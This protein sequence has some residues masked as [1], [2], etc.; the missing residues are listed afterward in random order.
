MDREGRPVAN[1]SDGGAGRAHEREGDAQL[2]VGV[3]RNE[4]SALR[5]FIARFEPILLDQARR[6]GIGRAERRAAVT[7]FLT[8]MLVKL[9]RSPAPRLLVSFVITS[10][11][12][13][14][15]DT[16]REAL[17]R[18]RHAL[19]A[20]TVGEERVIRSSCSEF[21]LRA[22]AGPDTLDEEPDNDCCAQPGTA[23]IR[24]LFDG[25]TQEERQL[26]I[27]SAHRVPLRD[28]AAWLGISY[29]SVKQRLSR[30]RARLVHESVAHLSELSA[31]DRANLTRR[32]NNAG[33]KTNNEQTRGSAA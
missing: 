33:V 5:Q 1:L 32:L 11:R 8:D 31:S 9:A 27:W 28:C 6:M 3:R 18:E 22:A 15:A 16:H 21:M 19:A 26:L 13:C 23:L 14:V 29:D 20:D 12:N 24:I 10:F 25:C 17:M 30:L 2:L 4:A 7:D